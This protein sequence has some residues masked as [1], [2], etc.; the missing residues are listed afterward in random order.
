M[1]F[2]KSGYNEFG[3]E[4]LPADDWLKPR[5]DQEETAFATMSLFWTSND[6]ELLYAAVKKYYLGY[7]FPRGWIS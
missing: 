3:I 1:A 5:Y 6:R 4:E 7:S 2:T